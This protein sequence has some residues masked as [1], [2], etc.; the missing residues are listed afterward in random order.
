MLSPSP[1][2][3]LRTPLVMAFLKVTMKAFKATLPL[4]THWHFLLGC[5]RQR[6]MGSATLLVP[7][8]LSN[9]NT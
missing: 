2:W 8:Y 9:F 7:A 1:S 3:A 4:Q 5:L 6:W